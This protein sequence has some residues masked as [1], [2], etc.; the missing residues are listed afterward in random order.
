MKRRKRQ[1][2]SR[3]AIRS[4][5]RTF[6]VYV[7]RDWA[8]HSAECYASFFNTPV[9]VFDIEAGKVLCTK[10]PKLYEEVAKA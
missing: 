4:T 9:E 6:E 1:A 7:D 10:Y 5:V 2:S 8:E 3:Y